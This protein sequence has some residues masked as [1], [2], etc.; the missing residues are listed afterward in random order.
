MNITSAELLLLRL[1]WYWCC[2]LCL[3]TGN[4]SL[5]VWPGVSNIFTM[6]NY[7]TNPTNFK[8]FGSSACSYSILWYMWPT[9]IWGF[10]LNMRT[11]WR[12]KVFEINQILL[13]LFCLN[14]DQFWFLLFL[15]NSSAEVW[16][17]K[18]CREMQITQPPRQV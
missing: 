7:F 9:R 12:S 15:R 14:K 18:R 1:I 2:N 8:N 13:F 16:Q 4:T 11:C 6:L 10:N 3:M 17:K 5:L